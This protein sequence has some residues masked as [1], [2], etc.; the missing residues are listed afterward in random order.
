MDVKMISSENYRVILAKLESLK[1]SVD[2]LKK[3][4]HEPGEGWLDN[5][6]VCNILRISSRQLQNYR[7]QGVIPF[8]QFGNKIYYRWVDIEAH[9]MRHYN[10][11]V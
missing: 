8:S 7:D 2:S 11:A 5:K 3:K 1:N 10:K 6:D 9:L 4:S